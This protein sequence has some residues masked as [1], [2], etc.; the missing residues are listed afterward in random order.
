MELV[1]R[2]A[3]NNIYQVDSE[4]TEDVMRAYQLLRVVPFEGLDTMWKQ[5]AGNAEHR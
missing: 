5:F 1:K 4:S 3:A 2:L